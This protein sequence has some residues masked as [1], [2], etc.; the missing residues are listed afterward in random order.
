MNENVQILSI[1]GKDLLTRNYK[2][3]KNTIR[4]GSLDDSMEVD[5]IK[6]LGKKII[7]LDKN[8]NRYY[9]NDVIT[10]TFKYA[11]K[12][13][14]DL[15]DEEYERV[16]SLKLTLSLIKNKEERK[17]IKEQIRIAERKINKKDIRHQLYKYGFNINIDGKNKHFVRYKRTSG[18]ARVGKCLFIS[19][20]LAKEMIDWS[21]A[22]IE[23]SE[24]TSMDCA[25][26]EA[27]I[28]LPTSSAIDRFK[29]KAENVL[30][31]DDCY[32]KFKDT[33][34]AT[35]FINEEYDDNGNIVGGDLYTDVDTTDIKNNLFD[36]E[37]LLDKS[38][39]EEYGYSD[40]A[41]LQLRN[42][43]FKG[44]GVNTDIQKFFKDNNIT[45]ISQL[46]GKTIATDIKQIK[47]ITTPSS[48]KYLKF[49]TFE[50]W[51]AHI[52]ENWAICKYEKPQHH[53]NGMAQ[54]HYQLLNTLGMSKKEMEDFL[55]DTI[56]YINL[57][58]TDIAVFKYH[59]GINTDIEDEEEIEQKNELPYYIDSSNDFILNMLEINED[60]EYTKMCKNYRKESVK[61]Y[62]RN[63]R[64][65]HILVEGNYSIMVSCP[66]EYL[67]ASIGKFD[68]NSLLKPFECVSSKFKDGERLL[69]VRSP[70]P[71]MANIAM[72]TNT[73]NKILDRYFN[74][75]SKEVLYLSPI[76]NNIM[77]QL[78]S[79]DF[80]GDAI[81]ITNNKY[82]VKA[83]D[84]LSEIIDVNGVKIKRFLTSTDFT[85]K[86]SIKRRYTAEDL[87][88]TDIK[89][90]A[91]KIGE[92]IN[93]A[94]MLNS[95]YW[96]K[97]YKGAS[98]EELLE[99]YKDISN[100]NILSCIEIDR[101]KKISPIDARKELEKIRQKHT[102]GTG[103]IKIDGE[104]KEVKVRP[105]FFKYLDGGM[106]YKFKRFET[107]M[108]YLNK[109]LDEK[110][111]RKDL[112]A[113][114]LPLSSIL[115]KKKVRKTNR[116]TIDK[117]KKIIK[118]MKNDFN[119]I[120]ASD[121]E[122][123]YES[124]MEA[125]N[126]YYS[127]LSKYKIND[128][129]IYTIINRISKSDSFDK[130][131]EYKKYGNIMLTTLFNIN[132][133]YFIENIKIKPKN[134]SYLLSDPN[135][136]IKIYGIKFKKAI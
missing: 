5:K 78:S 122:N 33:V 10:V 42:R 67:L 58:K 116:R 27:Y 82:L 96:D 23:H 115:I 22:G 51:L 9:T 112:Y 36:G 74:T 53:F 119:R 70:E 76:N 54:T 16:E 125:K 136:N 37:S 48:I 129:I 26:M 98:E 93:L 106:N 44:I 66:Y 49:G 8:K 13:D 50:Q 124:Y 6:T 1:E 41:T 92:I 105:M 17:Q 131:T 30:L 65:G 80:D 85:P 133:K 127:E 4:K 25:G 56:N 79:C 34:M 31:I 64:R 117:I 75:N 120:W 103:F 81:L 83:G 63:A 108:D 40:K 111:K 12:G 109:I 121:L 73:T 24:G 47:L 29:L 62:I 57:L 35:K 38:I 46:N 130:Y 39:F 20:K 45:D 90:S 69:G 128:E 95:L 91:N 18:S 21:F 132:K 14:R 102:L 60:F 15:T 19:D 110:I 3:N 89:C 104:K 71:T 72:F 59:L 126:Y 2:V 135:G 7:K 68:G 100:L 86:S 118:D 99:L 97:K 52:E 55:E 113:K 87:A 32:S 11:C 77:E 134:N 61:S 94:Q 101:A 88:D 43:F 84:R 28:S 123:K 114:E 107:G